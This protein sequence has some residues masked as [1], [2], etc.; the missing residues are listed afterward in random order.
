MAD[1]DTAFDG[2]I[3]KR[4]IVDGVE[5]DPTPAVTDHGDLDGLEDD[6]H[7][8][9]QRESEKGQA[10]GYA[11]LGSDGLVPS[12]QLPESGG[13]S[14][15]G[16]RLIEEHTVASGGEASW[17]SAA[18][19]AGYKDLIVT[20]V[21]QSEAVG[22]SDDLCMRF[23]GDSGANYDYQTNSGNASWFFSQG[24]AAVK[25]IVGWLSGAGAGATRPS[26]SQIV[27][28]DYAGTVWMKGYT[29]ESGLSQGTAANQQWS[30]KFS[31]TWRN[32]AAITTLTFLS[33]S[34]SD[35]TVGTVIRIYGMQ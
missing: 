5:V 1:N 4:L 32:T 15:A 6:D 20:V 35:L 29:A 33:G 13:G 22:A 34:G 9:Y 30:G 2:L 21:G 12:A 27:I 7:P 25:F 19:P 28:H 3:V 8:Q 31:G 24:V 23:N 16:L 18:I 11:S 26:R 14:A 17:T 10:N